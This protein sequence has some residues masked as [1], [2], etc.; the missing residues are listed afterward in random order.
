MFGDCVQC[1]E[2]G[3]PPEQQYHADQ[4]IHYHDLGQIPD[5]PTIPWPTWTPGVITNLGPW[6]QFA[7]LGGVVWVVWYL[8]LAG[9]VNLFRRKG[10]SKNP[11]WTKKNPGAK[12][13]TQRED[14]AIVGHKDAQTKIGKTFFR[15][16]ARAHRD[17]IEQELKYK[18]RK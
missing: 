12:W 10:R 14:A 15:G 16:K 17:S 6:A 1:A 5:P 9:G 7:V 2:V 3:Q 4:G 11:C 18:R 8:L 13:H